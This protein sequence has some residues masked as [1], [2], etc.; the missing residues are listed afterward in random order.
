[1]INLTL[2]LVILVSI[3]IRNRALNKTELY[4]IEDSINNFLNLN[5]INLKYIY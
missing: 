3:V 4:V 5:I 2:R 1:M